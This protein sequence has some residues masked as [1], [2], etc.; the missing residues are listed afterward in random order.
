ME[1]CV[2]VGVGGCERQPQ[3]T[4]LGTSRGVRATLRGAGTSPEGA[5]VSLVSVACLLPEQ[6]ARRAAEARTEGLLPGFRGPGPHPS[7]LVQ[8]G[9]PLLPSP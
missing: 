4:M 5:R 9:L 7:P 6:L 2:G 3:P 8:Q 1:G